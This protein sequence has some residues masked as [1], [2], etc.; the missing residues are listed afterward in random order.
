MDTVDTKEDEEN[1]F[2]ALKGDIQF[3]HKMRYTSRI[4]QEAL[5]YIRPGSQHI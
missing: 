4:P 2:Q 3:F 5:H 1:V